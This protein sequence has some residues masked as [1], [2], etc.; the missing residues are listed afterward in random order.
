MRSKSVL[1]WFLLLALTLAGCTSAPE[2]AAEQEPPGAPEVPPWNSTTQVLEVPAGESFGALLLG[3]HRTGSGPGPGLAMDRSGLPEEAFVRVLAFSVTANQ[4]TLAARSGGVGGHP[5]SVGAGNGEDSYSTLFLFVIQ[6]PAP[7]TLRVAEHTPGG[8]IVF[9]E[10]VQTVAWHASGSATISYYLESSGRILEQ[11]NVEVDRTATPDNP[12]G[13]A[14][15]VAIT[16]DHAAT[17]GFVLSE[18]RFFA[19]A[20]AVSQQVTWSADGEE[21]SFEAPTVRTPVAAHG[22][23][24]ILTEAATNAALAADT[25]GAGALGSLS[26]QHF[27]LAFDPA[28]L[29]LVVVPMFEGPVPP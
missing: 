11:H 15:R 8:E 10:A 26:I 12:V 25:S 3:F 1:P 29:G 2:P 6:S 7:G 5:G 27:T 16:A 21:R 22:G 19:P 24:T 14:G 4:A 20:G 9:P 13:F 17:S 23:F 18:G 28:S